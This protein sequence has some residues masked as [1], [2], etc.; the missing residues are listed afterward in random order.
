M[1]DIRAEKWETCRGMGSGFGFNREEQD[2]DYIRLPDLI[3][4]LV[5]VVSKNGN[6]LLNVGPMADGTIPTVQADLL[7]GVGAWLATY[8]EAIYGTRPWQRAEATTTA[9]G[10]VRFTQ[11]SSA[12]GDTLYA[13]FLDPL[14]GP[15]VTIKDLR[16][17]EAAAARDLATGQPVGLKQ[18]GDDL[19]L[20]GSG[21]PGDATVHAVAITSRGA[22]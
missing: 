4:M 1:A 11:R 18:D 10:S 14:M 7:R 17:D 6:L 2:D 12:A 8:G 15:Q 20:V 9:G 13:L 21:S 5:D 19:T 3:R 22:R 16:V